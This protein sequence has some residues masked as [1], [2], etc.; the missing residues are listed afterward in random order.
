MSI[1]SLTDALKLTLT[2]ALGSHVATAFANKP[3]IN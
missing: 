1:V 2:Y 3:V